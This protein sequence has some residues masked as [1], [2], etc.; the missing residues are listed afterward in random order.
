MGDRSQLCV[1]APEHDREGDLVEEGEG[2]D[3]EN[4]AVECAAEKRH[5]AWLQCDSPW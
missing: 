3:E 4:V 2:D 5:G 1:D